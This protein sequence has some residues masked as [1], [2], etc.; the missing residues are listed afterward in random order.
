MFPATLYCSPGQTEGAQE[1]YVR[2]AYVRTHDRDTLNQP[3]IPPLHCLILL[4]LL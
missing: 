2:V 1:R 4:P 3:Y